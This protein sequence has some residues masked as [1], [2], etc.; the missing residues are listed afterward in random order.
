MCA[1]EMEIVQAQT[2]APAGQDF[3]EMTVI[4]IVVMERVSMTLKFV[5]LSILSQV[6]IDIFK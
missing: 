3:P 6:R 5:S 4:F 2:T 1:W